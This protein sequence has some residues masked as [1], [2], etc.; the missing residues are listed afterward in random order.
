MGVSHQNLH[1]RR[2]PIEIQ[3]LIL[4]R[5][6]IGEEIW[7]DYAEN[8][9][10]AEEDRFHDEPRWY[11]K[12]DGTGIECD[13]IPIYALESRTV[14]KFD[15]WNSIF[16]PKARIP[17]ESH[18]TFMFPSTL[19]LLD[20]MLSK[21]FPPT[22]RSLIRRLVIDAT[23]LPMYGTDMSSYV[24]HDLE[25]ALRFISGLQVDTFVYRDVYLVHD[26][27]WGR[28]A[29]AYSLRGM[30]ASNGWRNLDFMTVDTEL[31]EE[32]VSSL[33]ATAE[34]IRQQRNESDF[35]FFLPRNKVTTDENGHITGILTS[36][37]TTDTD[38]AETRG[39]RADLPLMKV[40]RGNS[41]SLGPQTPG[42]N[43]WGILEQLL[44]SM[45]WRDI[46]LKGK[47]LV[48][49]GIENPNAHL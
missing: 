1:I 12:R 32:E 44:Q 3:T 16:A 10:V 7:A 47:Y 35:N 36:N 9:E 20:V 5:M 19:A 41:A 13:T 25:H 22:R 2:L 43:S 21:D 30:L 14:E 27:G 33:F 48:D 4:E 24:T 46:R 42:E 8:F 28:R 26:D 15:A 6:F 17:W 34:K 40:V 11:S 37:A 49:E 38:D 39:N 18:A 29:L 45:S 31:K 23:P